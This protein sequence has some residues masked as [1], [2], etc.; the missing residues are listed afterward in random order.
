MDWKVYIIQCT[1]D[2]LYTGITN[3]LVK[4]YNDHANG[5]GAKYFRGREPK[6]LV[7]VE[8]GYTRSTATRRELEIKKMTRASKLRLIGLKYEPLQDIGDV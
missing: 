2:S 3:D 4:R 7:Y 8:E 1:D 5:V 6:A